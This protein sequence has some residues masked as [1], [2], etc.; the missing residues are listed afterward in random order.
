MKQP[1]TERFDAPE[2]NPIIGEEIKHQ[3]TDW[4]ESGG[5]FSSINKCHIKG[6]K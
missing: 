6:G 3:V 5:F 1:I 2:E 4:M